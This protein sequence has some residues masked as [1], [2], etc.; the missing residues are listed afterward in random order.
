MDYDNTMPAD[1]RANGNA[2]SWEERQRVTRSTDAIVGVMQ[3]SLANYDEK[4]F[5]KWFGK[6]N[7]KQSDWMVKE[8]I[9]N[10]Y[11]FLKDGYETKWTAICCKNAM[12]SCR[13]CGKNG[14]LAFVGG[15]SLGL[16]KKKSFTAMRLCPILMKP[17]NPDMDIGLTILHEM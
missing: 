14:V 2:C 15:Y 16:G 11:N 13:T 3:K 5:R 17:G 1:V 8:R 4:K 12:G 10:T 9:R 7:D 6:N